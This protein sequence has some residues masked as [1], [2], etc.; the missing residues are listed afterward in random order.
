MNSKQINH[1]DPPFVIG[2]GKYVIVSNLLGKGSYG[3]VFE[4][5][6]QH[7]GKPVAIKKVR[8]LY[9]CCDNQ[10]NHFALS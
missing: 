4:G 9:I 5:I 2:G 3:T 7:T 1:T 10:L 8:I 6:N